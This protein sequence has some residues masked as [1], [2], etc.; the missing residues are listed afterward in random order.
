MVRKI[1][2]TT[3]F[4][5][6]AG[7]QNVIASSEDDQ[8]D[9]AQRRDNL[10]LWS[11]GAFDMD[12]DSAFSAFVGSRVAPVSY[13]R[14]EVLQ[15]EISPHCDLN[16]YCRFRGGASV[17]PTTNYEEHVEK[18]IGELGE[19]F[20]PE[21]LSAIER[22]KREHEEDC[23]KSCEMYFCADPSSPLIP[24]DELVGSTSMKSY[25]MGPVPPEDFAES[26]GYVKRC[27]GM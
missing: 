19:R 21:F 12:H 20:G 25:S 16:G 3:L 11:R 6:F 24:Y 22:N 4:V 15:H 10:N 13:V 9:E 17:D 27:F 2:V 5:A 26:F 18:K 7:L 8:I 14:Q 23:H 1:Q